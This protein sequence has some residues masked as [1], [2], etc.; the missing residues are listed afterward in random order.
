ML[1]T[2]QD[3][4]RTIGEGVRLYED[5]RLS[6]PYPGAF[7]TSKYVSTYGMKIPQLLSNTPFRS[8]WDVAVLKIAYLDKDLPD[9][10]AIRASFEIRTGIHHTRSMRDGAEVV[11]SQYSDLQTPFPP[12]MVVVEQTWKALE[13]HRDQS[14]HLTRRDYHWYVYALD[15][16]SNR[17]VHSNHGE[18]LQELQYHVLSHYPD[19]ALQCQDIFVPEPHSH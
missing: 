8:A 12:K 19:Y 5:M 2:L 15:K 13:Q 4:L 17:Y 9:D 18:T 16:A 7:H 1:E 6:P 3:A 11:I 14:G 10:D